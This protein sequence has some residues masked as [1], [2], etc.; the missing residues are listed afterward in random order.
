[1]HGNF[2]GHYALELVMDILLLLLRFLLKVLGHLGLWRVDGGAVFLL[3][4]HLLVLGVRRL[5]RN[6]ELGLGLILLHRLGGRC[7][8]GA[9]SLLVLLLLLGGL[10]G[11]ELFPAETVTALR[12]LQLGAALGVCV[13][14]CLVRRRGPG[15]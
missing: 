4:S 5:D 14:R 8:H 9:G 3:A 10:L 7:V 2:C 6:V 12:L 11:S 13:V 15:L 1:M